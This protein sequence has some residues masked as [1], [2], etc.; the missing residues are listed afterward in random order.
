MKP[1]DLKSIPLTELHNQVAALEH[2]IRSRKQTSADIEAAFHTW[3]HSMGTDAVG[4]NCEKI[5]LKAGVKVSRV[6]K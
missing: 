3:L 5:L 6:K 1:T 4:K 2:E